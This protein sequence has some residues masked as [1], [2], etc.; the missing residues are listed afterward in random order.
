MTRVTDQVEALKGQVRTKLMTEAQ[1]VEQLL[2]IHN[3]AMLRMQ[4]C[5][6]FSL[7]TTQE[8]ELYERIQ[9]ASDQIKQEHFEQTIQICLEE[10][11]KSANN[12]LNSIFKKFDK[13]SA[14]GY[15]IED[16]P[17]LE[18]DLQNLFTRIP[19]NFSEQK[20]GSERGAILL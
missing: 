6:K 7:D 18:A 16:I 9:S 20:Y 15:N 3:T 1:V 19:S 10:S 12:R 8:E 5:S 14:E 17:H 4:T 2:T 11:R 13:S